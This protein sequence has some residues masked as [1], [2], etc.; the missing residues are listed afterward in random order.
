MRSFFYRLLRDTMAF[1]IDAHEDLA[2]N[3]LSF[4]RDYRKS[5]AQIRTAE[6]GTAIPGLTGDTVLGW[7]DY[8]RG[9]VAIVFATLFIAPRAHAGGPWENQV[10]DDPASAH[11]LYERQVEYYQ[12]LT[13]EH[14]DEFRLICSRSDLQTV[15]K[16]WQSQP[17]DPPAVTHPVGLVLLMEGGEGLR[18]PQELE[19]W[20]QNGLRFF[21]PVWAGTR[22]CGGT[23]TGKGFTPEGRVLLEALADLGYTLDLSHMNEQSTLEAL[24]RY[25]GQII[26]THANARAVIHNSENERHFTDL[27]IRRL[28]ERDGV[29]G[30]LPFNHFLVPEWK[31]SDPREWVTLDHLIAHIDHVCQL[32]GDARHVAIGSDFDG[33]FGLPAVPYEIDTIADLQKLESRLLAHGY[34]QDEVQLIFNGNWQRVLEKGLP[35]S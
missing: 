25:E 35:A 2:Y 8:Q 23:F 18:D 4:N 3:A 17:A 20:R 29:M 34:H 9:Q 22:W 11:R 27:T 14:P 24:D 7:P 5:A 6:T 30:V 19:E 32:A 15:L 31:N 12:R 10:F 1:I 28:I 13:D 21:G 26:A 33:G 16:A